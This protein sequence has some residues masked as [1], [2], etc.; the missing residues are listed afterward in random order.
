[1]KKSLYILIITLLIASPALAGNVVLKT[2]QDQYTFTAGEEARIP[3]VVESS[4][5]RTNVGELAYTLTR[6]ET[7]GGLSFSQSSSQSQSFP[8]SPGSS[9]NA[10]TLSSAEPAEYEVSLSLQY[11]DDGKDFSS[12]LPPFQV[13]FVGNQTG[14]SQSGGQNSNQGGNPLTSTSKEVRPDNTGQSQDDPFAQMDEQMNAMRQQN[15]QM[16]QQALSGQGMQSGSGAQQQPQSAQQALQNNQMN[17]QSSALQ[18][19]LAQETTQNQQ[20]QQELQQQ[21]SRDPLLNQMTQNLNQAGYQQKEGSVNAQGKGTGSISARFENQ[22]GKSI[23]LQGEMK[24][25][26]AEKVTAS[27]NEAMP[28]PRTLADDQKYQNQTKDLLNSGYNQTGG[29]QIMTRN[30]TRVEEKFQTPDG[31][32]ATV[33]SLIR[34]GT[35]EEVIINKEEEIPV[36]WYVGI[37]LLLILVGLCIWAGYR[38]YQKRSNQEPEPVIIIG[39]PV[40]VSAET[41]RILLGAENAFSEGRMKD[42]YALAGQ[43]LRFFLSHT[44]GTG[45]AGTNEEII[46]LMQKAG[47]DHHTIQGMLDRCM[48]VEFARS[49]GESGEFQSIITRIRKIV[50]ENTPAG[51]DGEPESDRVS[52]ASEE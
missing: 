3:F 40:D 20:N 21:V 50:H 14:Q 44:F 32:N 52:P 43:G 30:E 11:R 39:E 10:I 47:K 34:N 46:A 48:M 6:K 24:N 22:T 18:Q 27:S 31:K 38:Y 25:G 5:P 28:I 42:A 17:T 12:D 16:L 13:R 33:T 49:E 23:D 41:E 1:M 51:T 26:S 2:T 19:Q 7:Q 9:Q 37:I 36:G 45:D 4:F 15:Q 8:I 35:V 29:S